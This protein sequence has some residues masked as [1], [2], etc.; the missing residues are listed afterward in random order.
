MSA[1]AAYQEYISILLYF[2]TLESANLITDSICR[3]SQEV[4]E[5]INDVTV[6]PSNRMA[7]TFEYNTCA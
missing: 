4:H 5:T 6:E 7:Y 1:N 3:P 2:S